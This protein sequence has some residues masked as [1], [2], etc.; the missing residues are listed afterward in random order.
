MG[1]A[2]ISIRR[3]VFAWVLMIALIVFGGIAFTRLGV[4]QWP[5]ID[6]PVVNVQLS[7][8]G[9]APEVME[10]DVVDILESALIQVEG[11]TQ[12]S[13]TCRQSMANIKLEFDLNRDIDAAIQDVQT[14]IAQQRKLLPIDMEP[15]IVMKTNP[16]DFP[17][18][19][20]GVYGTRTP[21]EISDFIRNTLKDQFQTIPGVGDMSMSGFRD[22]NV[23]V[24]IDA[25]LIQSYN[26]TID[27]VMAALSRQHVELPAG[28]IE[29]A[30]REL[31]IRSEGE[32]PTA[33]DFRNLI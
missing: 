16:E 24:W 13:S 4:S 22:L 11:I 3:P 6:L 32:A 27:E 2:Q 17:I 15:E 18:L 14:R 20:M 23:R 31:S 29:T 28:R 7:L 5:D 33:E 9:A 1:L 26:L 8:P 12:M 19:W 25:K 10:S 21:Q 30:S